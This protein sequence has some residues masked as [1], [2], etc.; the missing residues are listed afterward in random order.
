MSLIVYTNI[1]LRKLPLIII[2]KYVWNFILKVLLNIVW[3][4]GNMR[5]QPSRW[6]GGDR[7]PLPPS[8]VKALHT[9][10]TYI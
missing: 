6:A 3:A 10:N 2:A 5:A 7:N 9:T 1:S 8:A 4:D